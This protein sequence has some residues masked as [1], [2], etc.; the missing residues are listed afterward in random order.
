[1]SYLFPFSELAKDP[2]MLQ[3]LGITHVVNAS[4]GIMHNQTNTDNNFYTKF[5]INFYGIPAMDI[6]T[7]DLYPYFKPSA[8]FIDEAIIQNGKIYYS[9]TVINIFCMCFRYTHVGSLNRHVN[10][11]SKVLC[12]T[13]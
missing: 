9:K 6:E 12:V 10:Y 4:K 11:N 8:D 2:Q 7:F 13:Y 3:E 1:M 5:Q